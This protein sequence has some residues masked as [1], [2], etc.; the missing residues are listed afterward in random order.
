MGD[1]RD[2]LRCRK[3][4]G[5]VESSHIYSRYNVFH[6]SYSTASISVHATATIHFKFAII[7][8]S[9]EEFIKI[10]FIFVLECL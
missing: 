1:Q 8:I 9:F 2:E 4:G 5:N 6:F 10:S 3:V 7:S